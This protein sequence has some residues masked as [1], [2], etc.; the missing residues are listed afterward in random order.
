MYLFYSI[1][2]SICYGVSLNA[3]AAIKIPQIIVDT[4]I[5]NIIMPHCDSNGTDWFFDHHWS[6]VMHSIGN[7]LLYSS[8]KMENYF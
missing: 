5:L 6:R 7:H 1:I 4:C 8:E 3:N 2:D